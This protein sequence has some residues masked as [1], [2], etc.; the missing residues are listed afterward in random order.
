MMHRGKEN[1]DADI[2]E[3]IDRLVKRMG[4]LEKSIDRLSEGLA[5]AGSDVDRTVEEPATEER[6][7]RNTRDG[8]MK[9]IL[10]NFDFEKVARVCQ[11]MNWTVVK[12][13]DGVTVDFLIQDAKDKM[14]VACEWFDDP[15]HFGED[16]VTH[17]GP[18]RL[19]WLECDDGIFA[20]L[21]FVAEDWR[22]E[23]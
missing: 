21:S 5:D 6:D 13:P 19:W 20:D 10:R 12:C 22:V 9:E 16:F 4:M 11:Y 15:R 23:P 3:R 2:A 17:S 7:D 14:R 18:L 8:V 1:R